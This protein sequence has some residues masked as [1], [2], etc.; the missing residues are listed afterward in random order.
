MMTILVVY[1]I[2][3]ILV[4]FTVYSSR[5]HKALKGITLVTLVVL[6][7]FLYDEYKERLGAPID[8][9]PTYEFTYIHHVANT[10]FITLWAWDKEHGHRLY[11]FPYSQDAAKELEQAKQKTANGNPQT[12]QFKT[13]GDTTTPP[14]PEFD[15]ESSRGQTFTK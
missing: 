6:G 12:G 10:E 11:K 9:L 1:A 13:S 3:S 15:D 7:V 4:A 14:A 5:A 8:V 2:L